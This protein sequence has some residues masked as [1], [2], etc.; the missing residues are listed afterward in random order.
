MLN[1]TQACVARSAAH[2]RRA[3][4]A[5]VIGLFSGIASSGGSA[6][7]AGASLESIVDAAITP[8][9]REY[10][11]PGVAVAVSYHGET[12]FFSF[13][14][15]SLESAR[16][17]TPDTLFE[18]GSVSKTFTATLLAYAQA[19]GSLSLGDH[20]GQYLPGLRDAPINRASLLHLA[21][22][23]AGGLPLQMPDSVVDTAQMIDYFQQWQPLAAPGALRRYSN[24]SIGLAGY[25]AGIALGPEFTAAMETRVLAALGLRN[26]FLHVPDSAAELYAWGHNA[27]NQPIRV[28]PGMFDAEAY[29]IKTSARDLIR[30][31]EANMNPLQFGAAM[32]QAIET[33][34]TG[35]FRAGETVQG[36]AW[37][38]YPY[39]VSLD[40]LL[41]GNSREMAMEAQPAVAL[42]PPLPPAASAL[43]N[44]TGS[45][46]G[47]G[48]YVVF[49]PGEAVGIVI[50]A[51]RNYPNAARIGA[52]YRIL[53]ELTGSLG[54]GEM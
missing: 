45:T 48:A 40:R 29:G 22:Y 39:P 15:A 52:A 37:E 49:V 5:L 53:A 13:G 11:V 41:A 44:K 25:L 12:R 35:Y 46:N 14:V 27:D 6:A 16:P 38:R 17:V 54:Q 2:G 34:H 26:T 31:V 43:Y 36:L 10:A 23:T 4:L 8:V 47:F 20:P 30:F 9:M 51:N 19:A 50:L 7:G 33:T 24:P 3:C 21:T 18:V 32:R 42:E 1:S 28:N